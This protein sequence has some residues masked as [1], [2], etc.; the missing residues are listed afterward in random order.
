MTT[1]TMVK[2][3]PREEEYEEISKQVGM[4]AYF[5]F[6]ATGPLVILTSYDSIDNPDCLKTLRNRGFR[7]FVAHEIPVATAKTRYGMHFEVVCNDAHD[8][9]ELRI[10]DFKSERAIKLFSFK[11]FGPPIYYEC[12]TETFSLNR[13]PDYETEYLRVYPKCN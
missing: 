11:E 1:D 6:T 7:K 4:K 2:I 5:L 10:L 12:D 13:L 8:T 9:D 3:I